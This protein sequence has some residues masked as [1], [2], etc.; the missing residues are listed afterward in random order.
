MT[1]EQAAEL[2]R[3][4]FIKKPQGWQLFLIKGKTLTWGHRF[5]E[6]IGY[7][8]FIKFSGSLMVNSFTASEARK[9]AYQISRNETSEDILNVGVVLK[10][11]ANQVEALNNAWAASGAKAKP[12]HETNAGGTA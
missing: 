12:L 7:R 10:Q 4:P 1:Q 9:V 5:D 8:V 3:V 2:Q 11:M 6:N